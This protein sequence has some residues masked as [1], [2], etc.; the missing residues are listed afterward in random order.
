M[1]IRGGILLGDSRLR[2]QQRFYQDSDL[3]SGSRGVENNQYPAGENICADLSNAG[4]A[5][6]C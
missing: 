4:V 3:V 6:Q 2:S 1:D 5:Y